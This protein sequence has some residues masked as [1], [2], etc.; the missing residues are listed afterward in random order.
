MVA[1]SLPGLKVVLARCGLN[2]TAAAMVT[3]LI[4][5]FILHTGRMSCLR[6]AALC[7]TAVRWFAKRDT[8]GVLR[9]A[10]LAGETAKKAGIGA[11]DAAES[12]YLQDESGAHCRSAAAL[13]SLLPLG[14]GWALLGSLLLSVPQA[15]RDSVYDMA[16]RNRHRC[17]GP[18]GV[19]KHFPA[20]ENI[21][22]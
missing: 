17:L 7:G 22:P 14:G 10:P 5:A 2:A 20:S 4:A 3:R 21:L 12:M 9:F 8:F 18:C 13:R 15:I 19:I 16:A 1:E 6:A 11:V